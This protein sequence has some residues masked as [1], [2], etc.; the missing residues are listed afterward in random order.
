MLVEQINIFNLQA[1]Q[2][3]VDHFA[4]MCWT[5][6]GP[7]YLAILY[8]KSKLRSDDSL[9]APPLECPPQQL[10]IDEGAV[11]LGGVKE[12]ESQFERTVN[13]SN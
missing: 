2:G 8:A 7:G 12:I 13:G 9:L 1:S 11:D 10:F 5:A 3:S 6:V 4:D